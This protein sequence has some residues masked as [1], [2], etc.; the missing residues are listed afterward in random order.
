MYVAQDHCVPYATTDLHR[1]LTARCAATHVTRRQIA[2]PMPAEIYFFEA[3]RHRPD[4]AQVK[5]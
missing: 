5:Q 4:W 1:N 2:M 3:S